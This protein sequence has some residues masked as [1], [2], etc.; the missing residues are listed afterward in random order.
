MNSVIV[1]DSA[2]GWK[3]DTARQWSALIGFCGVENRKQVQ[4]IWKQIEKARDST[5]VRTIVITE[6]K[7]IKLPF[8][9]IPARCG[10][11]T[12]LQK[13]SVNADSPMDQW[14]KWQN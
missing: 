8:T 9:D 7:E 14:K 1:V 2:T 5:D 4:T 10:L 13:T 11:A 6:I 3:K 12:M